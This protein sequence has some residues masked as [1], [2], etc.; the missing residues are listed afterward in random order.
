MKNSKTIL[1]ILR[2]SDECK[3]DISFSFK[4]KKN[5]INRIEDNIDLRIADLIPS[6][7]TFE[8]KYGVLFNIVWIQDMIDSNMF[9]LLD[10]QF[11]NEKEILCYVAIRG[12]L[13][14]INSGYNNSNIKSRNFNAL[15]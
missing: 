5:E 12:K 7:T 1:Q 10:K 14:K 9:Y 8:D 3:Y 15:P 13:H 11:I 4:I 6:I 2:H